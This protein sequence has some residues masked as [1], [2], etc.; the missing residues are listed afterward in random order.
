MRMQTRRG[1]TRGIIATG[2]TVFIPRFARAAELEMRY[3]HNQP[4]EAPLHKR[5]SEMWA[6]VEKETGGRVHV[7]VLPENGEPAG[8]KNPLPLLQSGELEFMSLA[9]NGLSALVPAADVEATPFAFK[10]PA[11]VYAALDGDLGAYLR[12]ETRAK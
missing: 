6:A 8:I 2:V 10:D 1:V 12:D 3:L 9:G 7:T 5:A 11:Q 4:V